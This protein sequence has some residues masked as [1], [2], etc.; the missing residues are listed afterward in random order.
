LFIWIGARDS[1][2]PVAGAEHEAVTSQAVDR[3]KMA[4]ASAPGTLG[5]LTWVGEVSGPDGSGQLGDLARP[6]VLA[7]RGI[8]AAQVDEHFRR[9]QGLQCIVVQGVRGPVLVDRSW[10][11]AA[12]TGRLGFGRLLHARKPILEMITEDTLVL[13]YDATVEEAASAVI[14]RRAPG[15][16]ANAVVVT[17]SDGSLGVAHVSTIFERL[18][19]QY[20]YQSWHDP[21]TGLPNRRYLMEQIRV[22]ERSMG[23]ADQPVH[24]VL[25]YIDLDR[26]KDVNDQLGH[27]AGDQVLAQFARRISAASGPGDVVVRLGGDEF[28]ILTAAPLSVTQSEAFAARL[29]L[30]AAA[31]FVVAVTDGFGVVVEQ[32]VTIGAS[33]GVAHSRAV[34]PSVLVTSLDVLLKQ[35]DI[36]M[37]R[38]KEHGRGRAEHYSPQMRTGLEA[39]ETTQ[40]RRHM[41]RALRTAIETGGLA[42][43]YQPVVEL[44]S[45]RITG[46][47]ALARW[48][49]PVLGNVPPDQFI[50][51]AETTGLILDLGEWVLRAA[52]TQA[53]TTT[54]G[55]QQHLVVAVNVSPVQLAQPG[56]V[57]V[58][59]SALADSGLPA[60]RL[61]VEVTETAAIANLAETTA[62]LWELRRCG[63]QI[64]LDDFG[65]GHSSL[66][67]L[68][69]L[70]LTI[71]KIDRS[72]VA[73]VARSA[74]DAMLVRLVIE[75]AHTLGLQVCAEGIEDADQA[76]QLVA[77][78]CD[79]AQ[80]W[81]FGMP[82]P[83]SERLTRKL[84]STRPAV[85]FDV[86]A[87]PPVPFGAADE[88]ILVTSTDRTITYAS[89]TSQA[90]VGWTPQSL[91]GTNI[92]DH[93]H[94]DSAAHI[95]SLP[96]AHRHHGR[97]TH[98]VRHRDGSWLW[99]DTTT[100]ALRNDHGAVVEVMS[101]CRDVT[102]T[103]N[104]QDAL[105]NSEAKFRHAFDDAPTGMTLTGLDGTILTV[106]AAFADLVGRTASELVGGNVA[107]LTHPDD[108]GHDTDNLADL[109]SGNATAH[110][111][112]KRYLDAD[113][114]NVEANV[115]AA[116]V[117]DRQGRP[118]YVIAHI[119]PAAWTITRASLDLT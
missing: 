54:S 44:P 97:A 19:Q 64:A 94:P 103:T 7:P 110:H 46:V 111:V 75:T 100:K 70:P 61:C 76:Q 18:A 63:V 115:R 113:G 82:K 90:M 85:M 29:V 102:A 78:G 49:D 57:D 2:E 104:A 8:L 119:T 5:T 3:I 72:F 34:Q 40:A 92:L 47:E 68:R 1:H 4:A 96:Q 21:L 79:T 22:V 25:F 65:T 112:T 91:L 56:F 33:V 13:P 55:V 116:V 51:L 36:A 98:R 20:A 26:F 117:N 58:V 16:V 39:T 43:H 53:V 87:P 9:D 106:N 107:D 93:L 15:A 80:G 99:L 27:G 37:Y 83:P 71:V 105:A 50:P 23:S 41:E 45:G 12:I 66:T 62:R 32:V 86:T 60:S 17:W 52:C 67:M 89:S 84:S 118:A 108:R 95:A 11:E 114:N 10:F 28:A 38:A 73:K 14:A 81:Y 35:A 88:L 42:V 77:M 101:V 6:A 30:E 74:Q 69:T 109:R 48:N 24:A 59:M 31:P